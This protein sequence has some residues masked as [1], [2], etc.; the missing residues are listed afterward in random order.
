MP[1]TPTG[2]WTAVLFVHGMGSQHRYGDVSALVEA[3]DQRAREQAN[4][5]EEVE[6]REREKQAEQ[7]GR[8]KQTRQAKTKTKTKTKKPTLPADRYFSGIHPD[9]EPATRPDAPPITYIDTK[10]CPEGNP[11]GD[12]PHYRFYEAYWAP[13]TA[14]GVPAREVVTWLFAQVAKP[15][16]GFFAKWREKP[17]LRRS[18]LQNMQDVSEGHLDILFKAY[19]DYEGHTSRSRFSG[20]CFKDFETFLRQDYTRYRVPAD[21]QDQIIATAKRWHRACVWAE[22]SN[23]FVLLTL[24]T[25]LIAV[26]GMLLL[27][28]VWIIKVL[29]GST[30]VRTP[31]ELARYI[32]RDWHKFA[33]LGSTAL[34]LSGLAGWLKDYFGDVVFWTT[35]EETQTRYEKRCQILAEV[36][37][38]LS[39][40]IEQPDCERV[41]I[42]AHSLGTAIAI[43]AILAEARDNRALRVPPGDK[44]PAARD[45]LRKITHVITYGSPIDKIHYFFERDPGEH[46]YHRVVEDLRGDI[47]T[48]PFADECGA[49]LI[50]WINFWDRADVISG[51]LESPA[52]RRNPSLRVDNRDISSARLLNPMQAHTGYLKRPPVLDALLDVI[53]DRTTPVAPSQ[54]GMW[55][56]T[57]LAVA[58]ALAWILAGAFVYC[59]AT[60]SVGRAA[61]ITAVLAVLILLAAIIGAHRTIRTN[62]A[63]AFESARA[64]LHL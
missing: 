28:T 32:K 41:V 18:I 35:Y 25:V 47:G 8:P 36:R 10:W 54:P 43:D 49:P 48:E 21:Q 55:A 33:I 20:S 38:Y 62:L 5:R 63:L 37:S 51:A 12:R 59:V 44:Y 11:E 23:L 31:M 22:V 26:T 6:E 45:L 34:V 64:V 14:G 19:D 40:V 7:A 1:Q 52:N 4:E 60:V 27:T 16:G 58:I 61:W 30:I 50:H 15:L 39:H 53:L 46:R 2:K 9:F 42:V 24:A 13:I 56:K 3:L 17:R 29:E 57:Q